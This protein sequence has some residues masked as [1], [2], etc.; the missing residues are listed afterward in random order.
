M[1]GKSNRW[2]TTTTTTSYLGSG[3][4]TALGSDEALGLAEQV[5]ERQEGK[6]GQVRQREHQVPYAL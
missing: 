6:Q 4:E 1:I 5:G 2:Y 3:N